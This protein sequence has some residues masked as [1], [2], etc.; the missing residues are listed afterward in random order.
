MELI[1]GR[2]HIGANDTEL[3]HTKLEGGAIHSQMR[4]RTGSGER[5]TARSMRYSSSRI[6]PGHGY[7]IKA[8]IVS[9]G[10]V[11]IVLFIRRAKCCTKWRTNRGT[12]S[13][14]SRSGGTRSGNTF[15]R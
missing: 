1:Q 15:K 5:I 9:E 12:S 6:F 7:R 4:R 3:L 11:S 13:A 8:S 10:I 14:R 2:V